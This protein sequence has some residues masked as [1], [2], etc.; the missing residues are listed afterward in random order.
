MKNNVWGPRVLNGAIGAVLGIAVAAFLGFGSGAITTRAKLTATVLEAKVAA[1]A[2]VC[3]DDAVG[4]WREEKRDM[5]ALRKIDAWD[6]R[7]K[8][9]EKYAGELHLASDKDLFDRVTR[10]CASDLMA[11][12]SESGTAP[13]AVR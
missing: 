5:A 8:L 3:A 10:R 1:Y 11:V 4:G 2:S 6:M 12:A 7:E 9:A 13:P